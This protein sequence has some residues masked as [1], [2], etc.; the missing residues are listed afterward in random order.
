MSALDWLQRLFA[1][2]PKQPRRFPGPYRVY[3]TDYDQEVEFVDADDLRARI[4]VEGFCAAPDFNAYLGAAVDKYEAAANALVARIADSAT[5]K[6][7]ITFLLDHSGSLRGEM[8]CLLGAMIGVYSEC[9]SRA[10]LPH[11]VLAF[12]TSSWRG[13]RSKARWVQNGAPP[14]PGRLCDL[15][16]IIYHTPEKSSPIDYPALVQ[17]T[18]PWLLKENVDGE[19]LVWALKRLEAR[20][21]ERKILFAVSDGAPVDDSTLFVNGPMILHDHL[22]AVV[23]ETITKQDME[24]YGLGLGYG[25]P[26]YYPQFAVV[27]DVNDIAAVALPFLGAVLG[28]SAHAPS[29][30]QAELPK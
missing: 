10:G 24:I 22:R 15:L 12:T 14:F 18:D 28:S 4:T 8:S 17:M 11:E 30:D 9:L 6:P 21:A 27:H 13:G 29:V 16:H 26:R 3:T 7:A 1:P 20:A 5:P 2:E 23:A 19:A 25:M